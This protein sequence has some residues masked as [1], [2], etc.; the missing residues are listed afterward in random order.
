S[1][2]L[3]DVY[4]KGIGVEALCDSPCLSSLRNLDLS[5]NRIDAERFAKLASVPMPHLQTLDL[6]GPEV[7]PY[8]WNVGQQPIMDGGASAWA[9]TTNARTLKR[10]RLKNGHLTDASLLAIFRSPE[11]RNLQELDLSSN[12][13]TASGITEGVVGSPLWNTLQELG[14]NHCRLDNAA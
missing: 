6:S 13:F 2:E 4:C 8:Y 1:L 3:V 12:A 5:G 11:L 14:L 7:N 9:Q 10:L